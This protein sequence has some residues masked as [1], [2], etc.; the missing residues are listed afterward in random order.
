[1]MRLLRD[2]ADQGRTVNMVTHATQNVMLCDKVV[3]MGRGGHLAF[4]RHPD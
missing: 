3:F 2:L 1:M 4:L